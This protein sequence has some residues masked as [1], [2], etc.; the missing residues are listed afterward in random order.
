VNKVFKLMGISYG[1]Y[2]AV[3][4]GGKRKKKSW[5]VKGT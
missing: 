1:P 2:M 5:E 4:K 3:P